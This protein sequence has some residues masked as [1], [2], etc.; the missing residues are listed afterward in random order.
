MEHTQGSAMSEPT[1]LRALVI[2]NFYRS[3]NASGENLSVRDEISGLRDRGW[4]VEVISANSDV[5]GEGDIALPELALRP[6]YSRRSVTRVEEA[7]RRFRPHVALIE[8]LFPLHSPWIIKTLRTAG[9]PVAAGV[10]SYRMFCAASTLFRDGAEC[11]EC[12]GSATN[13]PAIR[14]GCYQNSPLRTIP[15][16]A[17]LALHRPTFRSIDKLLAV[18]GFVRDELISAGF[19]PDRIAVRPNFVNDPGIPDATAGDGFLF[20]GRLS[21]DKGLQPMLEGWKKSGIWSEHRLRVAGSGLLA[22]VL[23]DLDPK[24]RIEPLGLVPH[25]EIL[26]VVRSSAVTVV[27]SLWPEPFGRGVIEAAAHG[28]ASLVCRSGGVASLVDDGV[29]GWISDPDADGLAAAF[30][31]AADVGA[32]VAFGHAARQR[33]EA[34]YTREASLSV[35]DEQLRRLAHAGVDVSR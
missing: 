12:V 31:R 24:F 29:T 26:D 9:I 14:H 15:L 19:D 28:R 4:D 35:L 11:R 18:S 8:N 13:F 20:A 10:R 33:Y 3:E 23:T 6:I 5:I 16:A 17:S 1:P 2:H 7:V 32:Q 34:L 22:H 21:E 27:P 25:G 30:Q